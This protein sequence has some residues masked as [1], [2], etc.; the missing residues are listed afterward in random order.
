MA[1]SSLHTAALVGVAIALSGCHR[2]SNTEPAEPRPLRTTI[3]LDG[4]PVS[5][6]LSSSVGK[7][8]VVVVLLH[9]FGASLESWS[10]IYLDLT[11]RYQVLRIDLRGFGRTGKPPDRRYSIHDQAALVSDVMTTLG[12]RRAVLVGHSYGAAVAYLTYLRSKADSRS[13]VVA[14][15]FIDGAIYE[16]DL[17][18]FVESLRNPLTRFITNHLMSPEWRAELVLS[19]VFAVKSAITTERIYR[20]AKYFDSPGAHHSFAQAAKQVIP[21]DASR[22]R[23]QLGQVSVPTLIIWG[24]KDPVIRVTSAHRLAREIPRAELHILPETGHVPH[25]ERPRE[26][27]QILSQFLELVTQ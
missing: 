27:L 24:A 6:E 2:M 26:T 23:D 5:Y 16:Q 7:N 13:E 8:D 19:R 22:L 21:A 18:F 11:K 12:I 17:P 10:D 15:T 20:Y 1:R 14:L 25:E 4:L 9:G 3:H